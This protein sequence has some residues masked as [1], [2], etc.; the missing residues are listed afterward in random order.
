L[1]KGSSE[2]DFAKTQ[3][4][5]NN[6][7]R[8]GSSEAGRTKISKVEYQPYGCSDVSVLDFWC[9]LFSKGRR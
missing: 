7:L 4:F 2:A 5:K 1:K 3:P 6:L 8:K 9:D